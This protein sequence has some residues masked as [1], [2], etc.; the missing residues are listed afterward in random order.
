MSKNRVFAHLKHFLLLRLSLTF[1]K[2]PK[3]NLVIE[4][5]SKDINNGAFKI[6]VLIKCRR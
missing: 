2:G 1:Q 3:S 5:C 6:G 4:L